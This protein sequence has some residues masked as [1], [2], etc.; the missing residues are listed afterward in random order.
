MDRDE[1]WK[2]SLGGGPKVAIFGKFEE[3]KKRSKQ[4][5]GA[6]IESVR[7]EPMG[8]TTFLIS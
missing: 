1:E 2:V 8:Y 5:D 4:V 6:T 7:H 3:S